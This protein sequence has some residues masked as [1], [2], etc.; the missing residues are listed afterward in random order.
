MTM[1]LAREHLQ[2]NTFDV[3]GC[4]DQRKRVAVKP[5]W[6]KD[7]VKQDQLLIFHSISCKNSAAMARNSFFF[8]NIVAASLVRGR[9]RFW[10]CHH[11]APSI[12][13]SYIT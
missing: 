1:L 4:D 13:L 3:S 11:T 7:A 2:K 9:I 5:R 10:L 6:S 8:Q 12:C